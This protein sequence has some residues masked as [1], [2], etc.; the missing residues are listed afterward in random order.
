MPG[1]FVWRDV[2]DKGEGMR[3]IALVLMV[4]ALATAAPSFATHELP[5]DGCDTSTGA[6]ASAVVPDTAPTCS[7]EVFC[8]TFCIFTQTLD[9]NGTGQVSGSMSAR[10][11]TDPAFG[12]SAT[13]RNFETSEEAP[14]P[15]CG[16]ELFRCSWTATGVGAGNPVLLVVASAAAEITCTGGGLALFEAVQCSIT[17]VGAGS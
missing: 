5:V 4:V 14:N 17:L 6:T 16:P 11:I 13:F 8:P 12:G 3:R 1:V 9:V 10:V 15:A 7:F 2:R